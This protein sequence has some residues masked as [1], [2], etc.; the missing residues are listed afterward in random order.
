[1]HKVTK[2]ISPD[3][4]PS[5]NRKLAQVGEFWETTEFV[6]AY[7][8]RHMLALCN[9]ADAYKLTEAKAE[10]L[11]EIGEVVGKAIAEGDWRYLESLAKAVKFVNDHFDWNLKTQEDFMELLHWDTGRFTPIDPIRS[12]IIREYY[13]HRGG[14][15]DDAKKTR[16]TF[17]P[18][19]AAILR[20]KV[21]AKGAFAKAFDRACKDVGIK[22]RK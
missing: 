5:E 3:N 11:S 22:W 19:I 1:M 9:R 14:S 20:R 7:H 17:M 15:V 6:H 16:K 2:R 13:Q 10:T 8:W 4:T 21:D 12:L 18:Y